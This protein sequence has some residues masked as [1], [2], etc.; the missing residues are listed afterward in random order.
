MADTAGCSF[1]EKVNPE[2]RRILCFETAFGQSAYPGIGRTKTE[3]CHYLALSR[4]GAVY[5]GSYQKGF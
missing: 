5:T 1:D 4:T 2:S 3:Y